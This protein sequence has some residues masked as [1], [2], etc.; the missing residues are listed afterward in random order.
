MRP[1]E[2]PTDRRRDDDDDDDSGSDT[3]GGRCW[4]YTHTHTHTDTDRH[5]QT[6]AHPNKQTLTHSWQHPILAVEGSLGAF[7]SCT[8]VVRSGFTIVFWRAISLWMRLFC[9]R[10]MRR[11]SSFQV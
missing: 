8:C 2:R 4:G 11:V 5:R 3:L 7:L 10:L 9:R 1:T 6:Q